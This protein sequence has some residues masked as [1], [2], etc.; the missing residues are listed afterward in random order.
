MRRQ[1]DSESRFARERVFIVCPC[2]I[3]MSCCDSGFATAMH[4]R[5][6]RLASAKLDP[7]CLWFKMFTTQQAINSAQAISTA[8]MKHTKRLW[9]RC[10]TQLP[11]QKQWWSNPSTQLSQIRQWLD[12]MGRVMLQVR[13]TRSSSPSCMLHVWWKI[14][15]FD[16]ATM[17]RVWRS[18]GSTVRVECHCLGI[19]PGSQ[20]QTLA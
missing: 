19:I 5:R 15:V 4:T 1:Q 17:I 9:L 10:P 2:E 14:D 6:Q 13:H 20:R 18:S 3:G 12:K 8:R 11:I 7:E 16:L